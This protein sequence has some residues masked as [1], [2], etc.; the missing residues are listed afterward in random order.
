[1]E[2]RIEALTAEVSELKKECQVRHDKYVSRV[3]KKNQ[4]IARDVFL[5]LHFK[6]FFIVWLLRV[7]RRSVVERPTAA[8]CP[9]SREDSGLP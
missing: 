3:D 7:Y 4:S 1:M 9:S 8:Q 2:A 5:F 6:L